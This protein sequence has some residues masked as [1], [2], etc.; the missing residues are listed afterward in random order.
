MWRLGNQVRCIIRISEKKFSQDANER[1]W[2]NERTNTLGLSSLLPASCET[3]EH[4]KDEGRSLKELRA[5]GFRFASRTHHFWFSSR[6]RVGYLLSEAGV[7]CGLIASIARANQSPKIRTYPNSKPRLNRDILRSLSSTSRRR[8]QV[9]FSFFLFFFLRVFVASLILASI[10]YKRLGSVGF[11]D[12][13]ST[14]W[15]LKASLRRLCVCVRARARACVEERLKV[16]TKK[17]KK[18]NNKTKEEK[19]ECTDTDP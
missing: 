8:L 13:L 16:K 18:N 5:C 4:E 17:K 10:L 9:K 15:C 12:W 11:W 2:T 6:R 1:G 14:L 19:R 3:V 7:R